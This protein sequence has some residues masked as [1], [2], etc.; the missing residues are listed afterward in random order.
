[1]DEI[2]NQPTIQYGDNNTYVSKCQELLMVLGYSI[3]VNAPTGYF[4]KNT[5]S[6]IKLFQSTNGLK[7]DGI[8]GAE[9]WAKLLSDSAVKYDASAKSDEETI[10]DFLYAKIGN[11]YGTAGLMGNLYAE[12][13]LRSTNL[14]NTY[15]KYLGMT[16]AQYTAAVDNGSYTKFA[17]DAAGYGLAQWTYSVRKKN[18]LAFAKTSGKSI[19]DL[20]MQLDFLW[21]ELSE[22][23]AGTLSAI[24]SAA[25]V[26]AA[27]DAVLTQFERPANQ[28]DS[29]KAAR[30]GYG[31]TY[32]DK[33][34]KTANA[35]TTATQSNT[36]AST[37]TKASTV[38]N[39]AIGEIGYKEKASN[40][41][42][43]LST[44]NA[45]SNNWTKYARDLYN[46]GYYN[47]NKNGYAWCDVFVDWC[48][49]KAF[50]KT[51]GQLME[52]QTGDLGAA[53]PY[54]AGYYKAKGRY[55]TTPQYGDQVFFQQ[56]GALVHTGLVVGVTSS[57]VTVVEGNKSNMVQKVT[58]NRS[59]SYIA[60][61]GHPNYD[62]IDA[63]SS[64]SSSDSSSSA[65]AS[66]TSNANIKTF[67][68]WLNNNFSAGLSTD[69]VYGSLTKKAAIK[70][71]QKSLNR[72]YGTYLSVDGVFGTKT[73][74]ALTGVSL[75]YGS[76]GNLVRVLQGMLYCK[77]YGQGGFDG[78]FGNGT[79]AAVIAFQK[80]KGLAQDGVVGKA[81]F[82]ALFA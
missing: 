9:T 68:T 56:G 79:K 76:T 33:Y 8:V 54:S 59:N 36:Q 17:S 81:T 35:E 69:G 77:G 30:A 60:G 2:T 37:G 26:K 67:Q 75:K 11:A 1:M 3:G 23:Y 66:S 52:Y 32:Y 21:K 28:G 15:E 55:G 53:C 20:T 31:Q 12:S 40:A 65:S 13:A 46:A 72:I 27:S 58:Y 16:D 82:I 25:S 19:G 38:V 43:D 10:W 6:A 42:L 62:T 18:L 39:I 24:K 73:V 71:L 80:A 48:F 70:A 47:G 74:S 57:T 34:A 49:Y 50:G 14:Q 78:I 4:G 51:E 61:Y 64:G 29:V 63:P 45:G 22:D 7:A 44:A 5:L 41:Y